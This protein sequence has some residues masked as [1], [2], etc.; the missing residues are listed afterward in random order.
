M[1]RKL[2]T[3]LFTFNGRI[4]KNNFIVTSL[5]LSFISMIIYSAND[6]SEI[7]IQYIMKNL[8]SVNEIVMLYELYGLEIKNNV[9]YSLA[10][11]PFFTFLIFIYFNTILMIKRCHDRG[12]SGWFC[13][14][15]L[16]PIVGIWPLYELYCLNGVK[17][18]NRYGKNPLYKKSTL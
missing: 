16:I 15:M 6:L 8:L 12:R 17:D 14:Y 1:I 2:K 4:S 7:M 3:L 11:I 18:K 9:D 13:L 5:I 10:L